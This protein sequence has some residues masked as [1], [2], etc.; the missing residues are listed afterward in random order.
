VLS[1]DERVQGG[2]PKKFRV[3]AKDDQ[4]LAEF[5]EDVLSRHTINLSNYALIL[6]GRELKD[7][8]ASLSDLGFVSGCTIHAGIHTFS[9]PRLLFDGICISSR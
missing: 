5:E 9:F 7:D 4:T 3:P 2:K 8:Y 6:M 1:I